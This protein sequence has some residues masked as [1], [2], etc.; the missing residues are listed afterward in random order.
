MCS[1]FAE[2]SVVA[3]K[4]L[5][6]SVTASISDGNPRGASD[7][8]SEYTRKGATRSMIQSL[9]ELAET[10][11]KM[12]AGDTVVSLDP[13]DIDAS[14]VADRLGQ[15]VDDEEYV[16]LKDAIARSGQSSPILVRPHP[17]RSG[18]YMIV[19]GHRRAR[20]ARELGISVKAIV[21]AVADIDH[22]V[23][24]GQENTARANLSFAEKAMF[25]RRLQALG[26]S[27]ETIISALSIDETLLSRMMSVVEA[28]PQ[29][30]MAALGAARGVGRDRWEEAKKLL[31]VP[32]NAAAAAEFV[33]SPAFPGAEDEGQRFNA[34]LAFLKRAR[35]AGKQR[36]V[37]PS[38]WVAP[39]RRLTVAVKRR[40]AGLMIDF[41]EENA[42]PFG[43]WLTRR[44]DDLYAE[45]QRNQVADGD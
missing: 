8:R 23:A 15:D 14:F 6:A 30:V 16:Q 9:D 19:F 37:K 45:Y 1:A 38:E 27:R 43:A 29:P 12:L 2:A 42:K 40:A 21:K 20:A 17:E 24:Q 32:A 18:R 41:T 44:L 4:N 34:L 31:Q 3:R 10:S 35:R 26:M 7:T 28:V 11:M 5:L 22:V 25:A 33:A 39:D 36:S 13:R